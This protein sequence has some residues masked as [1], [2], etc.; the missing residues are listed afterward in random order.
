MYFRKKCYWLLF[1]SISRPWVYDC[2]MSDVMSSGVPVVISSV[3][4][5][6]TSSDPH[7]VGDP[8]ELGGVDR[9]RLERLILRQPERHG[10]AGVPRQAV[11]VQAA[12][13]TGDANLHSLVL[14]LT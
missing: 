14:V 1:M 8:H 11:A 3:E 4:S 9:H 12:R 6:S 10:H 7:L 5:F 2:S 13:T